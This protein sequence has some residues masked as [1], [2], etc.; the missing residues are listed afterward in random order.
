MN[1]ITLAVKTALGLALLAPAAA[2]L[3]QDEGAIYVVII[4]GSRAWVESSL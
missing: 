4:T 3:A 2:A 1:P